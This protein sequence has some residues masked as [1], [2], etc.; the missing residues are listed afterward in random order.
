ML[1]LARSDHVVKNHEQLGAQ[2]AVSASFCCRSLRRKIRSFFCN[3]LRNCDGI[4]FARPRANCDLALAL[5]DRFV[6]LP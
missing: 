2:Q 3:C 5:S 6:V 1:T 4:D